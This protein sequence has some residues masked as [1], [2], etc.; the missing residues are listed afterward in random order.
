MPIFVVGDV[1]P[2]T[3]IV[4]ATFP[5]VGN[6]PFTRNAWLGFPIAVLLAAI[7][8]QLPAVAPHIPDVVGAALGA[9]F[10]FHISD[11]TERLKRVKHNHFHK[12]SPSASRPSM[13]TF[14]LTMLTLLAPTKVRPLM[15]T[16]AAICLLRRKLNIFYL[17]VKACVFWSEN[18]VWSIG[19]K[20]FLS[21]REC[22]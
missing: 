21:P 3:E 18:G 16:F 19:N 7:V 15:V 2:S 17:S 14:P 5:C 11:C 13:N 10:D 4:N 8:L 1:G 9:N 6:L 20:H 12:S 22:L